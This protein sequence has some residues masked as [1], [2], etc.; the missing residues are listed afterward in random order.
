LGLTGRGRRGE[1]GGGR[2][3]RDAIPRLMS[4]TEENLQWGGRFAEPPDAALLAFGSSLEDDLVL[5]PFDVRC[6]HGHVEA[7]RGGDLISVAAAEALH[8][9]LDAVAREIETGSFAA[10]AR[11]GAF[12]DVHGA[13]DA[14]VRELTAPEVGEAL[15][16]GRSRND[17]VATTL[18]LYVADRARTLAVLCATI[19]RDALVR[20]DPA[21]DGNISLAGTTHW[22]PAQPITLAFWL[23]AMALPFLRLAPRLRAIAVDAMAE[24]PLGSG[25]L[26]GST[27]PLNR[28]AA[29]L[30]LGFSGPTKNA[31]DTVGNRDVALDLLEAAVRAAVAAT[32]PSEEFVIWSTPAFGYIRLADAASTGSSLMPQKRNPDPF[33]LVRA[34]GK[35]LVGTYAS[36][37]ATVAGIALS[38]HRDLQETKAQI[39]AGTERAIAVL[40][41]FARAFSYV[42]FQSA[43]MEANASR[44]F[45]EATDVADRLIVLGLSARSAHAVVGKRIRAIDPERDTFVDATHDI[46]RESQALA[47]LGGVGHSNEAEIFPLTPEASMIAKETYGST[48]DRHIENAVSADLERISAFLDDIT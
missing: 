12:E 14:R 1:G 19:A 30:A 6:S 34:H 41:A 5:A 2:A 29:A 9:A 28:D 31:L 25:A 48:G 22:Q 18:R 11:A 8:R 23:H 13:I 4:D 20:A 47:A 45:T 33:E 40:R 3:A 46:V 36:A 27:L 38:Y 16:T 32:R 7:L 37:L 39:I 24:C 10:Y 44:G 26:A 17:Q 42:T 21:R 35:A 43:P 15:H